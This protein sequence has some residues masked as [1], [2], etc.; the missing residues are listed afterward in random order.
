MQITIGAMHNDV[1]LYISETNFGVPEPNSGGATLYCSTIQ[2]N[3]V[4]LSQV[5][6]PSV[7]N[8]AL[9]WAAYVQSF[10]GLNTACTNGETGAPFDSA[11]QSSYAAANAALT[12]LNNDLA[13][14]G[15][16]AIPGVGLS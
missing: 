11:V 14:Y 10:D 13:N 2:S 4:D 9:D 5:A 16:P 3:Y 6:S 15:I 1:D 12:H 8:I 7:A